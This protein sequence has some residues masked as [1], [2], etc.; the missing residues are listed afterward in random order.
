MASRNNQAITKP[1]K[2]EQI[3]TVLMGGGAALFMI[4]L[5][6]VLNFEG[7]RRRARDEGR[8]DET[9]KEHAK[10]R[11]IAAGTLACG[12]AGSSVGFVLYMT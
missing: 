2:R 12:I 6:L 10:S 1:T 3:A 9:I 11:N 7:N 8:P 5:I 4:S